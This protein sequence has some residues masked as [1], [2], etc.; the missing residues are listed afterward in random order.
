MNG[1]KNSILLKIIGDYSENPLNMKNQIKNYKQIKTSNW[2]L[3]DSNKI[4]RTE[5]IWNLTLLSFKLARRRKTLIISKSVRC[6]HWIQWI[7][8][9]ILTTGG[10]TA[11]RNI[12][13]RNIGN[14]FIRSQ[15]HPF[16][17]IIR[18]KTLSNS[19]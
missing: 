2:K 18:K 17:R 13:L 4:R 7:I 14:S 10:Q 16:K 1:K 5:K 6:W 19:N 8:K 15:I 12:N 11:W 9:T 3:S